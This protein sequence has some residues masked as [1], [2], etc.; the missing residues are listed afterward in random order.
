MWIIALEAVVALALLVL[1]VWLTM[2]GA[3]RRDAQA[4]S[5]R[6]PKAGDDTTR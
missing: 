4:A 6:E 5:K 2:G 3:K 1:I